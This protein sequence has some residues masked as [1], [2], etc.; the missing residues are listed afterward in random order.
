VAGILAAVA[1][2]VVLVACYINQLP[3]ATT[4]AGHRK[5]SDS[6]PSDDAIDADDACA[7]ADAGAA[8]LGAVAS[9][10]IAAGA[11][12]IRRESAKSTNSETALYI[13]DE[14][15]SARTSTV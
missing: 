13:D 6:G 3:T 15:A 10:A 7:D 12:L 11:N 9:A 2:A 5:L 14:M 8:A 1:V 4:D